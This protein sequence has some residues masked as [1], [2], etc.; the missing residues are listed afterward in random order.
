MKKYD[1]VVIG[2]GILGAGVAQAAALSGYKTLVLEK[3]A[4]AYG[5]SS[6]S[7]KL[8]HGGLRYLESGQFGLVKEALRERNILLSIAPRLV[9]MLPFYIPVYSNT[10]RPIWKIELGLWVY[11]MFGGGEFRRLPE[12]DYEHLPGLTRDGLKAVFQYWDAQTDDARLTRAVLDSALRYGAEAEFPCEFQEG[13]YEHGHWLV[14]YERDE[15]TISCETRC[16]VNATG[17][18]VNETLARIQPEAPSCPIELVQGSH[19]ILDH[20]APD[21]IYYVESPS[22]RRAVFIMPWQGQLMVGTTEH[23]Y[24]GNPD[25]VAPRR[26]EIDYLLDVLHH[27]FPSVRADLYH[28]FSGL[29]VLPA[30]RGNP[31]IRAREV[32]LHTS[33]SLP[34]L[35]SVIGGKLTAYR[36]TSEKVMNSLSRFLPKNDHHLSSKNISLIDT[37]L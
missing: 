25:E 13:R 1:V 14:R 9:K 18:W 29:R 8:I 37:Q 35:L 28:A 22:D 2:A 15:V 24:S 5:T 23:V 4:I 19:I 7:S 31:F 20:P 3:S 6:R 17:P 32:M 11:K 16:L 26:E 34:G 21:G 10:S 36:S 30:S 33:P 12:S 27:Y